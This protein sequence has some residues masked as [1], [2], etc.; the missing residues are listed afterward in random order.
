MLFLILCFSYFSPQAHR[1]VF[2][3]NKK[4]ISMINYTKFKSNKSRNEKN[5]K[6][7]SYN[8]I[9]TEGMSH[10]TSFMSNNT[11]NNLLYLKRNYMLSPLM[12]PKRI[13]PKNEMNYTHCKK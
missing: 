4:H 1:S 13:K 9:L 12:S 10:K 3:R 7:Q 11:K 5:S 2:T 8:N 6:N